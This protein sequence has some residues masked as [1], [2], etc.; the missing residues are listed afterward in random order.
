MGFFVMTYMIYRTCC[1]WYVDTVLP[2]IMHSVL[3]YCVAGVYSK[4]RG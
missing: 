3:S 1:I 4:R 2:K